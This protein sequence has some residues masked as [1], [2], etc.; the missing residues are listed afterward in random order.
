MAFQKRVETDQVRNSFQGLAILFD[1]AEII[2]A[3]F[4]VGQAPAVECQPQRV[5]FPPT[6]SKG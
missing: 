3:I 1:P 4:Q 2:L 6:F 5:I